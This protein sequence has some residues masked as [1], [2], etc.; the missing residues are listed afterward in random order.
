MD[1]N[2]LTH[3][4]VKGMRWGVRRYQ[5]ADGSLT[6]RGIKKYAKKGY[7][8]DSF[9]RNKT[10]LGKAYDA[11][12]G[13]HKIEASVLYDLSSKKQNKA[14]AEQYLRDKESKKRYSEDTEK[15]VSEMSDEELRK[16]VNRLQMEKQ[17]NSLTNS[18]INRGKECVNKILKIGTT[19]ATA[20]TTAITIYNNTDKIKKIIE[21]MKK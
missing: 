6:E 3:Y 9:R 8:Q 4:G 17:Y 19:V 12:T 18:D 16:R 11:Y 7:A 15:K 20:T 14:R 21:N 10:V 2:T 5:N 1:N 13:A